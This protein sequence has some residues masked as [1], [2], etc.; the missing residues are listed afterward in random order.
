L[1]NHR[2]ARSLRDDFEFCAVTLS[3]QQTLELLRR[4]MNSQ[5]ADHL[6]KLIA[7]SEPHPMD[8]WDD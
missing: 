7:Q 6:W 2:A 3:E 8:V 1:T 4:S 5:I